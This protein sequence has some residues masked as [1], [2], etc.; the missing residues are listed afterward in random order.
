MATIPT[1]ARTTTTQASAG[2][3]ESVVDLI[4]NI[5]PTE[6]PILSMARSTTAKAVTHEWVVD[7]LRNP[8]DDITTSEGDTVGEGDNLSAATTPTKLTNICQINALTYGV[9]GTV[10]VVGKYGRDSELAYEGAKCSRDIKNAVDY[11][12]GGRNQAKAAGEPRGIGS[13]L[14]YITNVR[15]DGDAGPSSAD[16]TDLIGVGTESVFGQD[17]L[18]AAMEQCYADGAKPRSMVTTAKQKAKFSVFDGAGTGDTSR[19]DRAAQT[20]YAN[21]DVYV[22]NF[23]TIDV[24]PSRHVHSVTG[25]DTVF[26]L[27]PEYL[28]VAYLRPWQQ[29]DLAK[30]GDSMRR[31]MVVEFTLEVSNQGAHAAIVGRDNA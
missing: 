15:G 29:F 3:R 27:D 23:G 9:S 13:L 18:D 28:K 24:L 8:A 25:G 16:G 7:T 17:D 1:N 6:T 5:D 22:S 2:L 21:A 4:S 26:L 20:I 12:I 10:E 31:E 30:I 14:N 19:T 11:D